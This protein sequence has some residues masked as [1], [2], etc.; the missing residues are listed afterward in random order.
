MNIAEGDPEERNMMTGLHVVKDI[1]C[2]QCE[3]TLGWKYVKAY[4]EDQ[5]YKVGKFILEAELLESILG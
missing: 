3:T 5:K 1:M 4:P 2:V